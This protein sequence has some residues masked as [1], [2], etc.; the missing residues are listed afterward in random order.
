[1]I[2]NKEYTCNAGDVGVTP[3]L[4]RS[5]EGENGNPFQYFFLGNP[6]DRTAWLGPYGGPWGSQESDTT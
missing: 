3:G 2:K 6:M 1:M 4:G 5:P